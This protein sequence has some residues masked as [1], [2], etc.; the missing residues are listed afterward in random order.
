[1]KYLFNEKKKLEIIRSAIGNHTLNLN[2]GLLVDLRNNN[3]NN[4]NQMNTSENESN[5]LTQIA[6]TSSNNNSS[7]TS[8]L[9]NQNTLTSGN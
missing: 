4:S 2:N 6:N 7:S 9:H 3:N 1:M 8:S 5:N